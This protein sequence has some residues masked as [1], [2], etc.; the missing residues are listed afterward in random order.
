M[1]R[2]IAINGPISPTMLTVWATLN[3]KCRRRDPCA[4]LAT[5]RCSG[6]PLARPTPSLSQQLPERDRS[7]KLTRI[8]GSQIVDVLADAYGVNGKAELC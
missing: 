5:Y 4:S 2:N 7:R 6:G 3:G 1:T 8:E